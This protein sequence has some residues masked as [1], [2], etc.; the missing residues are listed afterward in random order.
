MSNSIQ[1]IGSNRKEIFDFLQNNKSSDD[2]FDTSIPSNFYINPF[3]EEVTII[4]DGGQTILSAK[5]YDYLIKDDATNRIIVQ[6]SHK[7]EIEISF[8]VNHELYESEPIQKLISD[9]ENG[10]FANQ[11]K[12][13]IPINNV[14]INIK[15]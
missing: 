11:L 2:Y 12:A 15:K 4:Y 9:C 10:T 8:L 3:K 14:N 13:I 1:W 6:K 7:I 5:M